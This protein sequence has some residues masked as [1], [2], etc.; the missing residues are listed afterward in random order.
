MYL[1]YRHLNNND[2]NDINLLRSIKN[3]RV[4]HRNMYMTINFLFCVPSNYN[5]MGY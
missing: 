3:Q 5:I 1:L 2:I 4:H